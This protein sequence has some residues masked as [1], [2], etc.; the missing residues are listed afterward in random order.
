MVS[1][2]N[3]VEHI[4]VYRKTLHV[5]GYF[6]TSGISYVYN[7]FRNLLPGILGFYSGSTWSDH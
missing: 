5:I 7:Y 1:E 4:Y 6:L 3:N 2:V